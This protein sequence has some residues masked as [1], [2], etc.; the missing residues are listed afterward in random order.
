VNFISSL[1]QPANSNAVPQK[2]VGASTL[3]VSNYLPEHI[4]FSKYFDTE[5]N[6]CYKYTCSAHSGATI[7]KVI[8]LNKG[9]NK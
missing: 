2:I 7:Q 6:L 8:L 3:T 4:N 1:P 5:G 9:E